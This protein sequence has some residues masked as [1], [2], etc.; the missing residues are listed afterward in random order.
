MSDFDRCKNK[1]RSFVDGLDDDDLDEVVKQIHRRKKQAERTASA[2]ASTVN[3]QE[4]LNQ[5]IKEARIRAAIRRR[6]D[7]LAARARLRSMQYIVDVWGDNPAKGLEALYVGVQ[8]SRKGSRAS[9]AHQQEA[10]L[11]DYLNDFEKRIEQKGLKLRDVWGKRTVEDDIPAAM[12]YLDGGRVDTSLK[13]SDEALAVAEVLSD[14]NERMRLDLN[15]AGAYIPKADNGYIVR[16]SHDQIRMNRAGFDKWSTDI[17][18]RLDIEATARE[19]GLNISADKVGAMTDAERTKWFGFLRSAYDALVSGVHLSTA[20]GRRFDEAFKHTAVSSNMARR[21]SQRRVLKFQ[22]NREW[23]AYHNEYGVGSISDAFFMGARKNANNT[24]LMRQL[25]PNPEETD[26]WL[27]QQVKVQSR[28]EGSFLDEKRMS[29]NDLHINYLLGVTQSAVNPRMAY[30]FQSLRN[31]INMTKLGSAVL[32]AISDIDFSAAQL[33]FMDDNGVP[34]SMARS[35]LNLTQSFVR[36][37]TMNK[38]ERNQVLRSL[39]VA[40]DSRF[41]MFTN[42]WDFSD[43]LSRGLFSGLQRKF[44]KWNLLTPWSDMMRGKS[45]LFM[46][47]HFA[48][49]SGTKWAQLPSAVKRQYERAGFDAK[50]WDSVIRKI[51]P[52]NIDGEDFVTIDSFNALPDSAFRPLVTS[53]LRALRKARDE[54]LAKVM[55]RNFKDPKKRKEAVSRVKSSFKASEDRILKQKR[56]EVTGQFQSLVL[57]FSEEAIVQPEART[58][59]ISLQGRRPGT[60]LGEAMRSFLQF[61]SF[62]LNVLFRIYGRELSGRSRPGEFFQ[63][64]GLVATTKDVGNLFFEGA[65][66]VMQGNLKF[67]GPISNIGAVIAMTSFMGGFS[68]MLKDLSRGR[69][70]RLPNT[71]NF[72]MAAIAQG[73]GLGLYGDF[74]FGEL[75]TRY[76][77]TALQS[78]G[79]PTV[80]MGDNLLNLLGDLRDGDIEAFESDATRFTRDNIPFVNTFYTRAALDYLIFYNIMEAVNP[81]YTQRLNNTL[82]REQGQ[83]LLLQ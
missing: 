69:T 49:H 70:P 30:V 67:N 16:Q 21:M 66:G 73:G 46:S 68:M 6:Q 77:S 29:N 24:G 53:E 25:G 57:D 45:A 79:G 56:V 2:A 35:Y 71:P 20:H 17:S 14:L 83:S 81:G 22:N 13:F 33:R 43:P 55:A 51:V 28:R 80:E 32:S 40:L 58:V 23:Y 41:D 74:F 78:F 63:R 48:Q 54:E 50:S 37:F 38:V 75:R 4:A 60:Y 39:S 9:I 44:F 82:E 47:H 1:A 19:A 11:L 10:I 76:G 42:R 8:E 5:G 3:L 12:D 52:D 72:F 64:A 15:D 65:T 59:S 61:K 26:D 7:L 62:A 31:W 18:E 36:H 27:Q 34:I